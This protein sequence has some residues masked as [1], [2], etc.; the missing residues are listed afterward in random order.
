MKK[1]EGIDPSRAIPRPSAKN[2]GLVATTSSNHAPSGQLTSGQIRTL[3]PTSI[4]IGNQE[5]LANKRDMIHARWEKFRSG[6]SPETLQADDQRKLELKKQV[7][8][9]AD[10]LRKDGFID[11]LLGVGTFGSVFQVS[12]GPYKVAMKFFMT[13]SIDSVDGAK[14]NLCQLEKD[15]LKRVHQALDRR[16]EELSQPNRFAFV[17]R[18]IPLP[19]QESAGAQTSLVTNIMPGSNI[20]TNVFEADKAKINQEYL[21]QGLQ[22]EHLLEYIDMFVTLSKARI[23]TKDT[24]R[25]QNTHYHKGRTYIFDFIGTVENDKTM[26]RL[27]LGETKPMTR[28]LYTL[29]TSMVLHENEN[30]FYMD[31]HRAKISHDLEAMGSNIETMRDQGSTQIT[32]VLE[33]AVEQGIVTK[34]EIRDGAQ[35]L[36]RI[37]GLDLEQWTKYFCFPLTE[38]GLSYVQKLAA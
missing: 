19:R 1:V 33:Q 35:E 30:A 36:V 23:D 22:D 20:V 21:R 29:L 25:S 17:Q 7:K 11:D 26:A 2:S 31:E 10:Q 14:E 15:E 27:D 5:I 3:S 4:P 34:D 9:F 8:E 13:D 24:G 16:R 18:E 32:K 37:Q 12:S 28:T 38:Q 6:I